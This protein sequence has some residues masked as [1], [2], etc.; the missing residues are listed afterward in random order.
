MRLKPLPGSTV[1]IS[2][3]GCGKLPLVPALQASHSWPRDRVAPIT[4]LPG[5]PLNL[6]IQSL[7][8]G[9]VELIPVLAH[10]PTPTSVQEYEP[11]LSGHEKTRTFA[12]L[13]CPAQ[14]I[15]SPVSWL[16]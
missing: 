9:V 10:A 5:K 12:L 8:S 3:C 2:T 6:L 11:E 7:P 13:G 16:R 4:A 15:S 14:K 1:I